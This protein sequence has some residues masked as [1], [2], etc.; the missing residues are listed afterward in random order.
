MLEI[1]LIKKVLDELIVIAP[2][3]AVQGNNGSVEL[4]ITDYI[5]IFNFKIVLNHGTRLS[6][7][8]SKL[9]DFG[10]SCG[11]DILITGHTHKPHR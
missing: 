11:A 2:V 4:E 3:I 8:F 6:N 1:L 5:E 9:Y 10:K 7:D